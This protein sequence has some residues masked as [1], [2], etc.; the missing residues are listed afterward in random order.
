[1]FV[2][3]NGNI[4]LSP[5]ILFIVCTITL[6]FASPKPIFS[7]N[8]S[9]LTIAFVPVAGSAINNKKY[10]IIGN[11]Y[12]TYQK[13]VSAKWLILLFLTFVFLLISIF[14]VYC[15]EISKTYYIIC[16]KVFGFYY[17]LFY[18]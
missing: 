9:K 1:M 8:V 13:I 6:L 17:F 11:M 16:F 3:N 2:L 5:K 15:F 14:F 4:P 7:K 18:W 10:A 12:I